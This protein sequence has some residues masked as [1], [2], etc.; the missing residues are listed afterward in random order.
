[1]RQ[2]DTVMFDVGG[3]LIGPIASD[4]YIR[5]F[6]AHGIPPD[7]VPVDFW[8]DVLKRHSQLWLQH[9]ASGREPDIDGNLWLAAFRASLGPWHALAKPMLEWFFDGRLDAV[10]DDVLPTLEWLKQ[11]SYRLGI[12]SNF[13]S[14]LRDR[15]EELGI[16]RYFDFFTVS[17]IE[18]VTKPA[19]RVFEIATERAGV[20]TSRILYVGDNPET[21]IC[22][23]RAA[24]LNVALIDRDG[25]FRHVAFPRIEKLTD[26]C[27]VLDEKSAE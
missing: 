24:N 11:R 6:T 7:M 20:P 27:A 3:T 2:Y 1:M 5:F 19:L 21:D 26:L 12:L 25:L 18:G 23:A 13:R 4:P 16:C 9:R 17:E 22:G 14:R 15:L 10:Y 8:R